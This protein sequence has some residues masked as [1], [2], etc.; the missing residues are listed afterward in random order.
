MGKFTLHNEIG[1]YM[2]YCTKSLDKAKAECDKAKY[3]CYVSESYFAPSPFDN[4]KITEHGKIVYSNYTQ[5]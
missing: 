1:E 2:S 4:N 5:R 3:Y